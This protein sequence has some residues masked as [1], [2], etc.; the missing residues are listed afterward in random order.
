[1]NNINKLNSISNQEAFSK[2]KQVSQDQHGDHDTNAKKNVQ[3]AKNAIHQQR[4]NYDFSLY[5][6]PQEE[7]GKRNSIKFI[8]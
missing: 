3:Q 7:S 8:A 4:V 6:D 1:M 5:D 2:K